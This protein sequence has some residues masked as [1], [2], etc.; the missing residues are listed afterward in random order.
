MFAIEQAL[1]LGWVVDIDDASI[2]ADSLDV[3]VEV[4]VGRSDEEEPRL[5]I[6]I[7]EDEVTVTMYDGRDGR[8]VVRASIEVAGS[9]GASTYF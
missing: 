7:D 4:T 3:E 8:T 1:E 9:V 5:I 2:S 6:V